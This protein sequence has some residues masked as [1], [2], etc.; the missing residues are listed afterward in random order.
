MKN[1]YLVGFMGTGK[2]V[3]AKV[4]AKRLNL[5]FID[6]DT[7]I[8]KKEGLKI[9]DIFAERGET[10]FR[11]LEKE[12]VK[13]LSAKLDTVVACGGGVVLDKDNLNILK[14][15]GSIICLNARPEII[16][17]RCENCTDRPL[18]N[19]ENPKKR[20]EEL[21]RFRAPFY[22][23]AHFNIDTSDLSVEEVAEKILEGIRRDEKTDD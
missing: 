19:I 10:Y 11:Q 16:L 23:Q 4:L 18:L 1:I 20:I 21:L 6:M 14:A 8:E 2:S 7:L 13:E 15:T 9:K 3:V 22:A 17:K 12:T 5:K